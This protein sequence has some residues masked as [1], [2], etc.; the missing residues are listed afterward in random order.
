MRAD[1]H[2]EY[3][4]RD[5]IIGLLSQDELERVSAAEEGRIPE[6]DE[7]LDLEHLEDGVLRAAPSTSG[8]HAL[9]RTAVTDS[10][11]EKIVTLLETPVEQTTEAAVER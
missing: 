8:K 6:G 11:W 2:T 3:Q 9:P 10:T 5:D 1:Q 4:T 7:Y